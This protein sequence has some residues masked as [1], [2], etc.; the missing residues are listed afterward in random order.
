MIGVKLQILELLV[1]TYPND[2]ELGQALRRVM[3]S[4]DFSY[5]SVTNSKPTTVDK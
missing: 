2:K 1:K 4:K 3:N 5:Q